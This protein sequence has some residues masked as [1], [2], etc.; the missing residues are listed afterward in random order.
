MYLRDN[1]MSKNPAFIS[2]LILEEYQE[3][4]TQVLWFLS[5]IQETRETRETLYKFSI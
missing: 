5:Q 1:K 4:D 3:Y 2:L